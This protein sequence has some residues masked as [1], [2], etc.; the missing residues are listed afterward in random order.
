MLVI[1]LLSTKRRVTLSEDDERQDD[2]VKELRRRGHPVGAKN[3]TYE[4]VDRPLRSNA[5]VLIIT[6]EPQSY[7]EAISCE[8]APHW[9]E[10]MNCE[11]DSHDKNRTWTLVG[12]PEGAN[13][14]K[15]KW[16]FKIKKNPDSSIARYKSRLVAK[17]YSQK[18]G[19]DY[20][21]TWAPVV[22]RNSVRIVLAIAHGQGMKIVH[23]DVKT[24]FLHGIM[25]ETLYMEQAKGYVKS[26]KVCKLKKT[27][28]GTKQ[29][30]RAFNK[31]LDK[32]LVKFGM[33][34][35]S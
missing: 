34:L 35:R 19:I 22:M 15:S 30:S 32:F 17:G 10:A 13:V 12:K 4:K 28:Y 29:A 18:K 25:E 5:Q 8:E 6:S 11:M 33:T 24:A 27:I 2:D 9:I 14:V 7:E 21:D 26:N 16:I 31:L 23:F 1:K 20:F 3:R